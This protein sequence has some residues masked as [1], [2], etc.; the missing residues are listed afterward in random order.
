[1]RWVFRVIG[2]IVLLAILG[3][4]ALF[5]IPSDRIAALAAQQVTAATGRGTM[6]DGGVHATIWP[7]LGIS[8]G[9]VTI[10]NADWAKAG[11]MVS[12][13]SL[14][15]GVDL[16]ALLG[17][18]LKVKRLV[19]DQPRIVFERRKDGTGNWELG[20]GGTAAPAPSAPAPS[21]PATTTATSSPAL[22]DAVIKGGTLVWID[23]ASGQTQTLSAIDAEMKLPD[24]AGPADLS[25]KAQMNGKPL[26]LAAHIAGFDDFAAGKPVAAKLTVGAGSSRIAFDGTAGMGPWVAKGALDADLGDLAAVFGAMGMAVP[27]L[28][29]GFGARHI[30]VKGQ[31]GYGAG[32]LSLRQAAVTLDDNALTGDLDVSLT[33]A[34][35]KVTA[36]LTAG[37]LNLAALTGSTGSKA[38]AKAPAKAPAA[39]GWSKAPID[40]SALG[41]ADADLSLTAQAIDLGT[42]ALGPSDLALSLKA[43]RAVVSL[44]KV[45]AYQGTVTGQLVADGSKGLNIST[46]L[47][48]ANIAL[49]PMLTDFAEYKRLS[50]AAALTAKLQASGPSVAALVGSLAG[51]G[52]LSI[53]KGELQGLDLAGMLTHLDPSYIGSGNKTIFD[54]VTA[55]YSI[56]NGVV[57]NSD[58]ALK[59]PLLTASGAGSVN[60]PA[61]TLDYTVTPT[62]LQGLAGDKGISVPL[63]ISGPWA[64]PKFGLDM[65]SALGQKITLEKQKV[66]DKAKAAAQKALA[67]KLGVQTSPGTSL[68]DT[69]KQGLLKMLGGG[70]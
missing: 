59:A 3:V 48:A 29:E 53:G 21:A 11:P 23:D 65:N 46:D 44:N 6:I 41:A 20:G 55:T 18:T 13:K 49:Q 52:S 9:P 67:D 22:D 27:D 42:L 43:G 69:A 4:A 8:T 2:L 57:T 25:L 16:A 34:R 40:A 10:A 64:A 15:V 45:T 62:A 66:E 38:G 61:R 7:E 54:G 30:A 60:L 1:M 68:K 63:K 28:P 58:L 24:P 56:A 37:K 47:K 14:Q 12:A 26:S 31:L 36:R 17:G 39:S 70:N 32:L 50:G 33:G 35:P 51:T 5:L 19:L